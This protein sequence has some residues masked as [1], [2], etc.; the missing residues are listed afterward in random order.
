MRD[1]A[2]PYKIAGRYSCAAGDGHVDSSDRNV[3]ECSGFAKHN[4]MIRRGF[5]GEKYVATF[6]FKRDTNTSPVFVV[7]TDA[8]AWHPASMFS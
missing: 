3:L 6:K 4:G 2:G 5:R 7:R 1:L 8:W